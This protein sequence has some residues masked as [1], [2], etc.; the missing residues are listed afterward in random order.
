MNLGGG[1]QKRVTKIIKRVKDNS[2]KENLGK[3][4]MS[5]FTKKKN[6]K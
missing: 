4:R 5:Y 2:Y 1:I 3:I 6:E